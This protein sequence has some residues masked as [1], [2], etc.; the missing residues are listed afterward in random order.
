MRSGGRLQELVRRPEL[1]AARKAVVAEVSST[2][3]D[4]T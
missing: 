3:E 2:I 4:E 1:G